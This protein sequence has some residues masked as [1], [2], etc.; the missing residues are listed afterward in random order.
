[1]LLQ[2]TALLL[3]EGYFDVAQVR[4]LQSL[5]LCLFTLSVTTDFGR[6][7]SV[8]RWPDLLLLRELQYDVPSDHLTCQ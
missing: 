2:A 8:L 4:V 6:S 1:M 3:I 5:V 7:E